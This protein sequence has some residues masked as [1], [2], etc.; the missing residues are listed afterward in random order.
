MNT[1]A[2]SE[3]RT[4]LMRILKDIESGASITI[5]SRGREIARIIPPENSRDKAKQALRELSKTAIIKNV[6]SPISEEWEA[7]Q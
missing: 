5:T 7:M 4:N 3:L 2:V 1:I 6:I